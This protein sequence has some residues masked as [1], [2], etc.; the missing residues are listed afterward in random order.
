MKNEEQKLNNA[1][2]PYLCN[3]IILPRKEEMEELVE[4]S[5]Q[6]GASCCFALE[7]RVLKN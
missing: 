2:I 1:D 7:K 5:G 4:V 6:D 3:F